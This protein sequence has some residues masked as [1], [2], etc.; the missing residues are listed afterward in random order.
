M[1]HTTRRPSLGYLL[2]ALFLIASLALTA[3]LPTACTPSSKHSDQAQ[4]MADSLQEASLDLLYQG[5]FDK[6]ILSYSKALGYYRECNDSN[7]ISDCLADLSVCYTRLSDMPSAIEY[8][9]QALQMDTAMH[10]IARISSS[11]NNLAGI[12]LTIKDPHKART[13][14]QHAIRLEESLSEPENLSI[15]Y[16]MAS[17]IYLMLGLRD[18]ALAYSQKAY[19]IDYDKS[20][21]IRFARR[22][23]T[24][25]DAMAAAGRNQ[26]AE[27]SYLE[28]LQW[29]EKKPSP[30]STCILHKQ[31]GNLMRTTGKRQLAIHFLEKASQE[32]RQLGNK[33]IL[34]QCC[35][36]LAEIT[37][38]SDP[39]YALRWLQE[40]I[41][42]RDE[43]YSEQTAKISSSY[44][45]KY[46]LA[47]KRHTIHMQ[48]EALRVQR[49]RTSIIV[50]VMVMLIIL[51]IFLVIHI[52]RKRRYHRAHIQELQE[53]LNAILAEPKKESAAESSL[54]KEDNEF[55]HHLKQ[56]ITDRLGD[57][58]LNSDSI[59]SEFCISQ[60]HLS[61]RVKE[62]TG[63]DT[64][65]FIRLMRIHSAT[66]LLADTT[67][68]ITDIYIQCGFESPSYFSKIF[69]E[70]TGVTPTAYRKNL[71]KE[72]EG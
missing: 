31:L 11:Y 6:A 29:L 55:L 38:A 51:C 30:I 21:T 48:E 40:S 14:I 46:D 16:G 61:R 9:S 57:S 28:A 37:Q 70:V 63:Q 68:N 62:I 47:E 12:Y 50:I 49:L 24:I 43:I 1:T 32:A 4:Q 52:I 67:L 33:N 42:I 5:K 3:V 2:Q 44:A 53:R 8:A 56:V 23:A 60:R 25:G 64:T 34:K 58:S 17:E 45:A 39:T 13:F 59:A 15:R 22:L 36:A 20:D 7:G 65:T 19:K 54:R 71:L 66:E 26:E 35:D 72:Q 18:S 27:A 10:D 41:A 69:K